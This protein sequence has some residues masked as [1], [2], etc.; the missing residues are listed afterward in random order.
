MN[1]SSYR[2]VMLTAPEAETEAEFWHRK[3]QERSRRISELERVVANLRDALAE[4][5]NEGAE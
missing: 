3:A 4:L 2:I 1:E 5:F